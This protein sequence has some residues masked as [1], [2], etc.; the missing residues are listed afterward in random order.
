MQKKTLPR[1]KL[2]LHRDTL[3]ALD[4]ASLGQ[5]DGAATLQNSCDPISAL[6][7]PGSAQSFCEWC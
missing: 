2:K 3:R 6:R 1:R 5:V 4:A 7:C